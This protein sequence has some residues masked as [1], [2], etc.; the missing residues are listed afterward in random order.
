MI[1][2]KLRRVTNGSALRTDD[3]VGTT[4]GMPRVGERFVML[5][6]PLESG[7]LRVVSTSPVKSFTSDGQGKTTFKT[8]NSTYELTVFDA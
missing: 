5:G 8:E 7:N 4:S 3:V 6:A 1:P 2:V